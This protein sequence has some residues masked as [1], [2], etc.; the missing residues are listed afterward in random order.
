MGVLIIKMELNM[1]NKLKFITEMSHTE[2]KQFLLKTES[3]CNI[4][5][6]KYFDFS[7]VLNEID[8]FIEDLL[9]RK[10]TVNKDINQKL[11]KQSDSVN[12]K[13]Y[14]NKDSKFDWRPL[15]IINPYLYVYLVKCITEENNWKELIKALNNNKSENI[16]VASIPMEA[17]SRQKDQEE[18]I[19]NWWDKVE[20]K[21]IELALKYNYVLLLDISNCYGSIYT[22]SISW[23]IHGK[24]TAK[25][26]QS[27]LNLLG[28]KIDKYIRYMQCNQT[29]GIPQG[30]ILMD[31]IAEIVLSY[32]DKLLHEKIS[33]KDE[34]N[35]EFTIIRYRDDY[36]IFS[37][38]KEDINKIAKLLND[39]LM[40]LNFKLNSKKTMYSDD[41]V[42]TSIKN[43]KIAYQSLLPTLYVK[44]SYGKKHF[45]LNLQKHL[46]QILVFSKEFPNSGSVVRMLSEFNILRTKYMKK[47]LELND[48]NNYIQCISII[49]E[50]MINNTR[51]VPLCISIISKFIV[52]LSKEKKNEVINQIK[53]KINALP[54]TDMIDIWLQRLVLSDNQTS[55]FDTTICRLVNGETDTIFDTNWIKTKKYK[56]SDVN[57]LNQEEIESIS[58][59]INNEEVALFN[60]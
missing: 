58:T 52:L 35:S 24:E 34:L 30:S 1:N 15:E 2:A 32:V 4:E 40:S 3:Y 60:Y 9:A 33:I 41:V 8:I 25:K 27:G 45:Q 13:I 14:A 38:S 44:D 36:R 16:I 55:H 20:Q 22:H 23:A 5:L 12:C 6:P 43:D 37:N 18:Q 48:Q 47:S 59:T 51:C 10:S 7:K 21:S 31:F 49:T 50:I 29:N 57:V 56:I 39:T 46:F 26:N 53:S 17:L 28:N 19:I 42:L 11:L 54:N